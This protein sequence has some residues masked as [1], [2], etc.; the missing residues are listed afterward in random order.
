MTRAGLKLRDTWVPEV[1]HAHDWL[2]AHPAVALAEFFDV[3]MISH[4]AR[5]RGRPAFRL[6]VRADQ[7]AGARGGIVAGPRV[8]RTDHLLGLDGRGDRRA[9]PDPDC[10]TSP[11]SPA[12]SIPAVG[13]SRGADSTGP[14]ELLFFGRLEYEKGVHDAIAALPRIRR[15]TPAPP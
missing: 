2:A 11:S 4:H 10:P 5:H 14:P 9:V 1:V 15:I 6:G 12:G 7:P 13:L 3:P 8:R